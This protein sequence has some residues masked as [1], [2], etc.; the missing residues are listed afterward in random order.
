M[1]EQKGEQKSSQQ[2]EWFAPKFLTTVG[3]SL[4][5]SNASAQDKPVSSNMYIDNMIV[6][7]FNVT[8]IRYVW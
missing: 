1:Q 4:E 2:S 3:L 7:A 8:N 6:I 5:D